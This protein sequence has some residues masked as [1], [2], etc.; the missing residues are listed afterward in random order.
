LR[1]ISTNASLAEPRSVCHWTEARARINWRPAINAET[2][3]II[4]VDGVHS[5]SAALDFKAS[6]DSQATQDWCEL[7]KD[8]VAM[9]N[10]GGGTI[11]I[12]V[13]DEGSPS[14]A[15]LNGILGLDSADLTNKIHSYTDQH[16]AAIEITPSL[17]A[18]QPVAIVSIGASRIP[19]VFTAHGGYPVKPTGQKTAFVK[20]SVYFRHGAKSEPGTSD[21]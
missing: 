11:I 3:Q 18:G 10:S 7:I 9:S 5:E 8:I 13:S 1:R 17:R 4:D 12:G 14:G 20:G 6:F 19:I 2:Q 21:D 16:F 15:E